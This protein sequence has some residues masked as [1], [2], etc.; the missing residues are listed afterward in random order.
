MFISDGRI[1]CGRLVLYDG[2]TVKFVKVSDCG[3]EVL[4]IN[5][6]LAWLNIVLKYM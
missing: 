5:I 4:T 6:G 1:I 3:R 2:F